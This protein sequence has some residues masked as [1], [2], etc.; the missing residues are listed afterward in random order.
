M[1]HKLPACLH[2]LGMRRCT[3]SPTN[4]LNQPRRPIVTFAEITM[5]IWL[6]L[7]EIFRCVTRCQTNTHTDKHTLLKFNIDWIT[8]LTDFRN[9]AG[10]TCMSVQLLSLS[11]DIGDFY[12]SSVTVQEMT[13]GIA[14]S[15]SAF[16]SVT[17]GGSPQA[18]TIFSCTCCTFSRLRTAWW[19]AAECSAS[20]RSCAGPSKLCSAEGDI[21]VGEGAVH[22]HEVGQGGGTRSGWNGFPVSEIQKRVFLAATKWPA[23]G[24]LMS[25]LS[26]PVPTSH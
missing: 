23:Q 16:S 15:H 4:I 2:T 10:H 17:V 19:W 22:P 24:P 8:T 13:A 5:K 6:H 21:V 14:V 11:V 20:R 25:V 1:G 12:S 18:V 3:W 9:I 7:A 26:R